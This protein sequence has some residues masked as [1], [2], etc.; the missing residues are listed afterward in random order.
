MEVSLPQRTC[1][2]TSAVSTDLS[3]HVAESSDHVPFWSRTGRQTNMPVEI[4]NNREASRYELLLDGELI[5]IADYQTE[6]DTIVFPHTEINQSKRGQGYG[7]ILVR[8]AL[9]D[10]RRSGGSVV[11]QCWYV[12]D[13]IRDNPGYANLLA[14]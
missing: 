10:V 11:P 9:D 13:F 8:Y 7:A 3:R 5:G 1:R 14:A 4:T 6:G 2:L 12:A